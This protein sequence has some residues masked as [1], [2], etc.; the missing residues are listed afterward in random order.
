[1]RLLSKEIQVDFARSMNRITFDRTV[2]SKPDM[3]PYVTLPSLKEEPVPE[4]GKM[5]LQV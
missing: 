2:T 3:F 1:M 5:F 4:R